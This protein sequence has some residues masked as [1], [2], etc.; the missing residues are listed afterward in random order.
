[1][2]SLRTL[3][4]KAS[5]IQYYL[6][7]GVMVYKEIVKLYIPL[8][9]QFFVGFSD[10]IGSDVSLHHGNDCTK[11]FITHIFKITDNTCFEEDFGVAKSVFCWIQL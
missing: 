7:A 5:S 4:I 8:I 10:K 1:M 11:T 9:A 2:E 6:L 3:T